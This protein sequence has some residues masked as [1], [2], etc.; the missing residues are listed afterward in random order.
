[1]SNTLLLALL[2][3]VPG[4]VATVCTSDLKTVKTNYCTIIRNRMSSKSTHLKYQ[5]ANDLLQS[6]CSLDIMKSVR[7]TK[8]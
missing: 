1:M 2:Q 5:K 6:E 4:Q 7:A 3:Q 8:S